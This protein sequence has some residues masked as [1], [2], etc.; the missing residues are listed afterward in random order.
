MPCSHLT[1]K[2]KPC[3][4]EPDRLDEAGNWVCHVHDPKG[5]FQQQKQAKEQ[6]KKQ[7]WHKK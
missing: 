3:P 7:K 4:I 1:R 6:E 5:V 2:G